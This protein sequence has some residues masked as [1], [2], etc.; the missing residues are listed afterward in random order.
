MH[1]KL[2]ILLLSVCSFSTG[3]K[4]NFHIQGENGYGGKI[5]V[6]STNEISNQ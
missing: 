3:I 4:D 5:I 1:Y 2:L 6:D